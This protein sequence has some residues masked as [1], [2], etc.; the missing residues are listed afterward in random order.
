MPRPIAS[1][2]A[3][4][5]G[6]RT[7]SAAGTD[8]DASSRL[9]S[10]A[11]TN[12]RSATIHARPA[13]ASRE[14]VATTSGSI[15]A[16]S[17]PTGA[18]PARADPVSNARMSVR[19]I[20]GRG[21]KPKVAASAPTSVTNHGSKSSAAAAVPAAATIAMRT[22]AP[23]PPTSGNASA[24]PAAMNSAS[25]KAGGQNA[26]A[27]SSSRPTVTIACNRARRSVASAARMRACITNGASAKHTSGPSSPSAIAL[28]TMGLIA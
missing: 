11:H 9:G 21:R 17:R 4:A 24:N 26:P 28:R 13:H 5:A 18:M 14:P 12:D 10:Q 23:R 3:S 20:G 2:S 1:A 16:T 25:S 6:T 27:T 8:A 7:P 19:S 22:V 15:A